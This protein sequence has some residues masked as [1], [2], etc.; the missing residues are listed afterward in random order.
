MCKDQ[1]CV[2]HAKFLSP[3]LS[4]NH[5]CTKKNIKPELDIVKTLGGGE[6][7]GFGGEASPPHPPV[8]ETLVINWVLRQIDNT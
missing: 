2:K 5:Q 1:L 7:G 8:D 6:V 4:I 3:F